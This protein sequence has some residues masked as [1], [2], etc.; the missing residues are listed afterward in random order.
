M[1]VF[2]PVINP[3]DLFLRFL[4]DLVLVLKA[5]KNNFSPLAPTL[6]PQLIPEKN[7]FWRI[8]PGPKPISRLKF[9][10]KISKVAFVTWASLNKNDGNSGFI[11]EN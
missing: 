7:S 11:V 1:E 6:S 4:G 5:K 3:K 9:F 8:Y 2:T 10:F